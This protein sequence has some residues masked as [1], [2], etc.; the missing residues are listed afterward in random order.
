MSIKNQAK[1][2]GFALA[3]AVAFS[4]FGSGEAQAAFNVKRFDCTDPG[5][6]VDVSGLGNTNLCI[7]GSVVLD[8]FCACANNGGNCPND[9]HKQTTDLTAERSLA[10]EPKNG[11]VRTT[12]ELPA[13][14]GD[15]NCSG[16]PANLDC[17]GGQD[18]KLIKFES[19]GAMFT[20][21]A[22]DAAAGSPCSCEGAPTVGDL[23]Q[24]QT[25]PP[26][27]QDLVPACL[28]LFP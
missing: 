1:L 25:C 23:P 22:T 2:A 6:V 10:V 9:A 21:C 13:E 5:V 28:P 20:I 7:Q 3:A 11:R 24:T 17:P 8:L 19:D 16:N 27:G 14:V 4:A 12:F 26:F 18:A 15:G